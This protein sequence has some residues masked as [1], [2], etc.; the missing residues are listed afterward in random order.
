ME[1]K[2]FMEI[3]RE[4]TYK[5]NQRIIKMIYLDNA[6]TTRPYDE[7]IEEIKI[8]QELFFANPSSMHAAGYEAEKRILD[9][10]SA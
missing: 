10:K 9:A 4:I 1:Y 2:I 5:F 3:H 6:A 7:V 8:A